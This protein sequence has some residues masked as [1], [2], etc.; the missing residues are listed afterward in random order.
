LASEVAKR[1]RETEREREKREEKELK[2]LFFSL[3]SI[4]Q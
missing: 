1:K 2:V 3:L 4:L